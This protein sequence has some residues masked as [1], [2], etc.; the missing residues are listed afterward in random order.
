MG[1]YLIGEGEE[2]GVDKVILQKTDPDAK[3]I[4]KIVSKKYDNSL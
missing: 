4:L 2:D 1:C 3:E